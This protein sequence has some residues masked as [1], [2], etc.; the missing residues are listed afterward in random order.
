MVCEGGLP[1]YWVCIVLCVEVRI[2][3]I[4]ESQITSGAGSHLC[5]CR[6]DLPGQKCC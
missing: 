4:V 6:Q 1:N 5:H 2:G 3:Y